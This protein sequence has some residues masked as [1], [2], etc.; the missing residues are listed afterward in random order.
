MKILGYSERGVINAL[1]YDILNN[2]NQLIAG[3]LTNVN[4]SNQLISGLLNK[5]IFIH[6]KEIFDILRTK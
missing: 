2:S 5:T 3:L 4:N 1:F 6:K